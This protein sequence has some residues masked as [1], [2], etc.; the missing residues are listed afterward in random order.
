MN[1]V[2]VKVIVAVAGAVVREILDDSLVIWNN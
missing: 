1:T 2:L